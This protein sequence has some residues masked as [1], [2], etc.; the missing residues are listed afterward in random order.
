MQRNNEFRRVKRFTLDFRYVFINANG[1]RM[2]RRGLIWREVLVM[3]SLT[4][5]VSLMG[6]NRTPVIIPEFFSPEPDKRIYNF[7]Q[8]MYILQKVME[9]NNVDTKEYEHVI[10]K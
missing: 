2:I 4:P 3:P 9:E 5:L 8:Q 7:Q 6:G 1:V 10:Q